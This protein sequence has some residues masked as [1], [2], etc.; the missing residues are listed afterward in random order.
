MREAQFLKQNAEKW[1]QYEQDAR[2][3]ES[4]DVFA[5]RFVELTD[6]LAYARTFY[7][8]TNTSKY[9]NGLASRFHQ[10]IYRNKRERSGRIFDFWQYELPWL[11]KQYQVQLLYAFIFFIIF[12]LLG[13]LSAYYD[14]AVLKLVIPNGDAYVNQTLE[15]IRKGDPFGVYKS[16]GQVNMFF[17]IAF[18]N[19][20]VSFVAFVLGI[21]FS[22][23]TLWLL[24]Q[25]GLMLGAFLQFFFARHLGGQAVLAIFIHGTIEISVIVVACCAGL[26]IGNSLLFPGTYSRWY[27]LQKAGRDAMKI[28][29]G[30]VPFFLIAAFLESFV[31]RYYQ[32]IPLWLNIFILTASLWLIIWYFILYPIRLHRLVN[33]MKAKQAV[34]GD[35][36][37]QLWMNKKLNSEK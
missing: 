34:S 4:P 23:G 27:A 30:L 36:N 22:V 9:L 3:S 13:A 11:F 20:K 35:Q 15:N 7:P 31:T 33:S 14:D 28:V 16:G 37:F 2:Q 32:V 18:N 26:V 17:Q 24:V 25:N 1:K 12:C 10:K 6:D 21:F 19:I 8:D 29:F 5:D